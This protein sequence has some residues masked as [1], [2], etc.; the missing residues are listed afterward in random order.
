MLQIITTAVIPIFITT[1]T[2][3]TVILIYD[4]SEEFLLLRLLWLFVISMLVLT[5]GCVVNIFRYWVKV[6]KYKSSK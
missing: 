4:I 5:L 3:L 2:L 1:A 6:P